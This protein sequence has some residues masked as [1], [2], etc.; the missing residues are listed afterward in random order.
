MSLKDTLVTPESHVVDIL[1]STK[2][3]DQPIML[4]DKAL[5]LIR[6]LSSEVIDDPNVVFFDPFCKAGEVLL[7][8]ALHAC[9]H[10]NKR[11]APLASHQEVADVIYSGKFFA[12]AP[13]ERHFLLSRR[14]F[15]G[16]DRSHDTTST[17]H[18]KNGNYLS[19]ID[20]KLNESKFLQELENMID[21]IRSKK[22]KCKIV[23]VGNPPYQESDGGAKASAK[24][25]YNYFVEALIDC[26]EIDEFSLV[27]PSRWFSG[28]KGLESFRK[29][30]ANSNQI[31][32]LHYFERSEDVFPTVHV[33]GGVCFLHWQKQH[34][35]KTSFV[36]KDESHSIDLSKFDII[37]DDPSSASII[38]KVLGS[39]IDSFVAEYAWSRK[40]FGL[41]TNF[42]SKKEN[43]SSEGNP[44][45]IPCYTKSKKIR[46]VLRSK[47]R[48]NA[49]KI[50]KWKVAI[51]RAYATGARRCTLPKHQI[52]L[53]KKGEVATETYNVIQAFDS[54]KE[55]EALIAYL[56]TDFCRYL[57][58]LR[59]LTQDIPRDRWSWVPY[60]DLSRTWT[61]DD[62]FDYFKLSKKEREHI[63][64]KIAEW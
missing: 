15:Y 60:M 5:Q 46:Y 61:D 55:A 13:D 63:K 36:Y 44:N 19:E 59:K 57:L 7:I 14:T 34:K 39:K 38:E 18:I 9:A 56:Q 54:K 28:G 2:G 62:L 48:I 42:F 29:K 25:V 10:K 23:T 31:K 26:G 12:L 20:G 37:P 4:V 49:D 64:K 41:P 22:G 24:P 32:T 51:P 35:G 3:R 40:P 43:I 33:Q 47:I 30:L 17:V 50:D 27:I 1:G 58:G 45:A 16:N 52:F 21:Y 6:C 8:A 11:R 53:I